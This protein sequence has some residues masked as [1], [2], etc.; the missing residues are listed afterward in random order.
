MTHLTLI[1]YTAKMLV[2]SGDL[3]GNSQ[4]EIVDLKNPN[5]KCKDWANH[6]HDRVYDV[7]GQLIGDSVTICGGRNAATNGYINNC[8][9]IGQKSVDSLPN[10]STKKGHISSAVFNN[11]LFV[12]GGYGSTYF[13]TTDYI[14]ENKQQIGPSMPIKSYGH[15]TIQINENEIL[16]TGGNTYGV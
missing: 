11:S 4:T 5:M 9:K 10:L 15:C 12:M 13:D 7:A 16:L 1:S 2:T 8:Y 6:P 3:S 14:S